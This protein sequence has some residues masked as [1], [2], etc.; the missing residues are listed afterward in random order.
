ME[1]KVRQEVTLIAGCYEQSWEQKVV[2]EPAAFIL[3]PGYFYVFLINMTRV[4]GPVANISDLGRVRAS[5]SW[6]WCQGLQGVWAGGNP[7]V[8]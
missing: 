6:P 3:L 1:S 8:R 2:P 4:W 7:K 5:T